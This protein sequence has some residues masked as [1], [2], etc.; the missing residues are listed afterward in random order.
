MVHPFEAKDTYNLSS[1]DAVNIIKRVNPNVAILTH[2]GK[3]L[4][5]ANPVY[6][7]REISHMTETTV[8]AASDGLVVNP[9][10]YA[11]RFRQKK[12]DSFEGPNIVPSEE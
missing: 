6:Q 3:E 5:S 7:A 1:D 2:F 12:L 8:I 11:R 9:T 10:E 4:I